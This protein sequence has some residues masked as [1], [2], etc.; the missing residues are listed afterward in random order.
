[1]R[2][3]S[4]SR[5]RARIRCIVW[6]VAALL[7]TPHTE[8]QNVEASRIVAVGDIHGDFDA[9]VGILKSAGIV[10]ASGRWSGGKTTLV[11]TGDFTDRGPKVRA[12]MDFLMDLEG[13]AKAAGGRVVVLLGNHEVMNLIGDLHDVTPAIYQ[14]FA[15]AQSE[16]RREAA[17]D[18]YVKW[19]EAH[20]SQFQQPP[21]IYQP[22]N[23][24]DWMAAHP[25][26]YVEYRMAFAPQGRYG[27]WLRTKQPLL[28][29]NDIVFLHGGLNPDRSPRRLEDVNKQVI[30][31]IRRWDEYQRRMVDRRM[32]LPY[33]ALPEILAAAQV[34]IQIAAQANPTGAA[35][36]RS[37]FPANDDPLNLKGL[38]E[39]DD[40][41]LINPDGP[42]WFRGYATWPNEAGAEQL[43]VL[44]DRYKV[45]RFVVGHTILESRRIT[46]RFSGS[47]FLI[48]TGMFSSYFTG[49]RASALEIDRGQ[50]TAIYEDGRVPLK[51]P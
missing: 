36:D 16:K 8:A 51:V 12:A 31:E 33:F 39:I 44:K 11:Q 40:W 22:V 38:L 9:F 6:V 45:A 10:D 1:M 20:A 2:P 37:G 34:E 26:G 18:S 32:V 17:Y 50:F 14:S 23:K 13:Q 15:D 3:S 21:R 19:C 25:I 41:S 30:G 42:L 35:P 29:L 7:L 49:G 28:Q 4:W 48:D 47:V 24:A 5:A 46:A 43:K 27:R